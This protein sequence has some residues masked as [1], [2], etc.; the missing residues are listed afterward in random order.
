[1][2]DALENRPY[3]R[4][5]VDQQKHWIFHAEM[6]RFVLMSGI[7]EADYNGLLDR[8]DL[9]DDLATVFSGEYKEAVRIRTL[10]GLTE[11][12]WDYYEMAGLEGLKEIKLWE[13]VMIRLHKA[14]KGIISY[15]NRYKNKTQ[16]SS[17]S[18]ND[19]SSGPRVNETCGGV[20]G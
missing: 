20:S 8:V 6:K 1:M 17:Q 14:I 2:P 16:G 11:A 18:G 5:T 9:V 10:P 3:N 7:A 12:T 4:E 19:Q 15:A 13:G